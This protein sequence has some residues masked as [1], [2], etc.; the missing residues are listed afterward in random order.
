[1][2]SLEYLSLY[3][4]LCLF[5]SCSKNQAISMHWDETG[6]SNPWESF[7]T[8]DSFTLEGYH[9]G[10]HDYLTA[11]DINVNYISSELDSSKIELCFACHCKTGKVITINIPKGDKQKL[12]RL[13]GNNQFGLAF[14]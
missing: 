9:Q 6:C 1:M 4:L 14:Y 13:S 3:A 5:V 11:E 2:K 8:L 12:K 10:I 7:I